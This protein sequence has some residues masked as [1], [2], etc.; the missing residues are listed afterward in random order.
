[1]T[2]IDRGKEGKGKGEKAERKGTACDSGKAV[3]CPGDFCLVS[4]FCNRT[5][6]YAIGI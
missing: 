6:F 4:P 2:Q 5:R 3:F 1:M